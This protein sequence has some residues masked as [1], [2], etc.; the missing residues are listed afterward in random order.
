MSMPR[1]R[2]RGVLLKGVEVLPIQGPQ[3]ILLC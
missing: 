1:Q 2:T 3:A